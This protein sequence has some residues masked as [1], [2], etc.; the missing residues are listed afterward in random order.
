MPRPDVLKSLENSISHQD[1]WTLVW[2]ARLRLAAVRVTPLGVG[3]IESKGGAVWVSLAITPQAISGL[4]FAAL[5]RSPRDLTPCCR[6]P[7]LARGEVA[8]IPVELV[9]ACQHSEARCPTGRGAE[10]KRGVRS[11]E[12]RRSHGQAARHHDRFLR[13]GSLDSVAGPPNSMKRRL[14]ESVTDPGAALLAA[15]S[16]DVTPADLRAIAECDY[17]YA[18]TENLAALQ[19]LVA[20]DI[21][22]LRPLTSMPREVLELTRRSDLLRAV[23]GGEGSTSGVSAVTRGRRA[24]A[25][26]RQPCRG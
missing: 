10:R 2:G 20:G 1:L 15:V 11:R 16:R 17:G 26:R 3:A 22:A 14:P 6:A 13:S 19:S 18:A 21:T 24:S 25:A 4:D 9:H 5:R 8:Q 7:P 12:L 23:A